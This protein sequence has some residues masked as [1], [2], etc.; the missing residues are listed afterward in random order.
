MEKPESW[1]PQDSTSLT[2][3]VQAD[4]NTFRELVQRLTGA[5]DEDR[6]APTVSPP[7]DTSKGTP[8]TTSAQKPICVKR[9]T[10]KLH[11]RRQYSRPKLEIIK[12]GFHFKPGQPVH[13]PSKP[14]LQATEPG[15]SPSKLVG[16]P[17]TPANQSPS[18]TGYITSPST[19][20]SNLSILD[21]G[22]S[23]SSDLNSEEE[24][25]AIKE[26]RFYLHPSPRSRLGNA[27]PE[28]LPLFPLT[29]PR[30]HES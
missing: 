13:S 12:P 3:F 22:K 1:A 29:S 19:D 10:F 5:P 28:L 17:T 27:E 7:T 20:F 24:E 23:D 6:Q 18:S 26:R 2:T 15:L 21:R 16:F 8:Q 14:G 30:A 25:R 11:E 9:P 4:T